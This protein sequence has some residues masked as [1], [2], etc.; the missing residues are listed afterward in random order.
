MIAGVAVIVL[1]VLEGKMPGKCV[2]FFFLVTLINISG[3]V[4]VLSALAGTILVERE[5]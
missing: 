4:G 2:T 1:L 3:A 5:W